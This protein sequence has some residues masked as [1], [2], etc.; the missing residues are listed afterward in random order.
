MRKHKTF[1]KYFG[2]GKW[3]DDVCCVLFV[4][5]SL[6]IFKIDFDGLYQEVGEVIFL[7]E[8]LVV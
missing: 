8:S 4:A 1:K 3:G 2:L 5:I 7:G 6:Y